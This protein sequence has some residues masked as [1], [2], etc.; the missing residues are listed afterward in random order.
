MKLR[1]TVMAK[2]SSRRQCFMHD[3]RP[4]WGVRFE[5]VGTERVDESFLWLCRRCIDFAKAGV[6]R[7]E[8]LEVVDLRE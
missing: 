2:R 4:A 1:L 6:D 5:V 8:S 7:G 3:T